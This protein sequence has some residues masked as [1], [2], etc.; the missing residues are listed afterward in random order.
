M[1]RL[2]I[3]P[4]IFLVAILGFGTHNNVAAQ[5]LD[6][7]TLLT[8]SEQYDK[9]AEMF[10]QLIQKEPGNS[11][12]FFFYGENTLQE[13]FADTISNSLTVATKEAKELYNKGVSA[14]PN[15]PLNYVGLAKVAFYLDDNKTAGEMR[16]KAKSFLLPYRN[17]KKIVPPAKDYAFTLAKLAESYIDADNKVDT[18]LALPFIREAISI[19]SKSRDIYL[20]AGDIFNIK[21]DGSNAIKYYNLAQEYDPKSPTANMKIGSIYVKARNLNAAIPFFEQ[22][23]ALNV[24]YAPAYRELGAMYTLAGRNDKAKENFKKY[25]D[26]TQGNI[27]AKII[28]VKA[29]FYTGEYD[30]AIK[31]VEEIFAV[32]KSKTYMNRIAGYSSYE[33]KDADYNK[34]LSYMETLFKT[35]SPDRIIKKDYIYMAKILLKKNLNYPNYV[36]ENDRLKVQLEREKTKYASASAADKAKLKANLDTLINRSGR[37]DKQTAKADVDIDRAFGEYAKALTYDPEDKALLNE[38]A[39]SYYNYR[40]FDEAAKTWSKLIALGKNDITDYMQIGRAYYV[41]EKYKSADSIFTIVL[42]MSPDY[43]PAYV[44]IARTYSKMEADAKTGL[45]KPKFET[46][47][48]KAGI[49]SAK[50]SREL[51]EAYG[52]L[53]YHYMQNENFGRAKDYYNRMINLDPN[54]KEYK[55]QGYNGLA[56]VDLKALGNEKTLE[57]RLPFLAKAQESYNKIIG[58]DP[59]NESAKNMLG[60]LQTLE[61]QVKAGINPNELKG[62]IKDAAGQP[63]A[64]A[65]I[66]VKDTAAET[67][68]NAKGEFK[69]EIP[70]AS[71]ALI[72]SAKG[73]KSKEVP[74]QRPLHAINVVLEQ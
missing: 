53:G 39:N 68:T 13:Y 33:K 29:L 43:I 61:K 35:V 3:S 12:Y 52:Y 27:P 21:N 73:F 22:A 24:N 58:I 1:K 14:N 32:D 18:A 10:K 16:A 42:K 49:D 65:S 9:A 57:G 70:M 51:V 26:L 71:E 56:N 23:I 50:Y 40:R 5:D 67:Y 62:I 17:I 25:L 28:Y 8:R 60:Y 31:N 72:I 7:A 19:D 2:I 11:R 69:F 66:R 36:K 30:E 54:N 20:I 15:E 44:Y 74:V 59:N 6:A 41:G 38:I 63:V 47:I 34:A 55:I 64:N 48:E 4:A 46:V 37:L 45:A